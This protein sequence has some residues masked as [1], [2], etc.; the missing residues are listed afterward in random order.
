[1]RREH[2]SGVHEQGLECII[3][4]VRR[5]STRR[6][7]LRRDTTVAAEAKPEVLPSFHEPKKPSPQKLFVTPARAHAHRAGEAQ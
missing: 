7:E 4:D 1:M 3:Q 2:A 6:A 5:V